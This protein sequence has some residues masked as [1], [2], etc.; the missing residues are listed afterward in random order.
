[1]TQQILEP[2]RLVLLR[3][4]RTALELIGRAQGHTDVTLDDTGR[5]QAA[6]AAQY[7]AGYGAVA[8]WSSDLARAGVRTATYVEKATGLAAV[9]DPRL[10]EFDVGERAGLTVAEFAEK[11]PEAPRPGRP[12]RDRRGPRA[13]RR[14]PT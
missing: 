4:G 1:M 2:R 11:F 3:H 5:E 6:A 7:L 12:V 14:S 13:R 10:R 8:L 9:T